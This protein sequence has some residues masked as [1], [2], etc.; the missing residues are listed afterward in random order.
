MKKPDEH[1][2]AEP[3]PL[4]AEA[5]SPSIEDRIREVGSQLRVTIGAVLAKLPG[6]PHRPNQLAKLLNCNRAVASRVLSGTSKSDPLE[7]AHIIPGPEPLRRL[8]NVAIEE[9]VALELISPA[10]L[11]VDHFD[12]LI[13][14][15]AGT[16]TALDSLISS[17]LPGA[18]ERF[19]LSNKYS[20]YKGMS[21]LKGAQAELWVGAA[22][23]APS[24]EQP[25]KHDL[26]WLNGAVAMQRL[27]RNVTIQ[28]SYRYRSDS[29]TSDPDP[30][31]LKDSSTQA[32]FGVIP[33]DQFCV[34]PPARL[35]ARSAG[36]AIHY[37][38]PDDLLGPKQAVDMFVVDHHP[39]AMNRYAKPAERH[40]N[41]LFIE[42]AMPVANL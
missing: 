6:A 18:R 8:L 39:A 19:E 7:V 17:T 16:R 5:K 41:S 22:I 12:V 15:E 26:T 3:V 14:D 31:Q 36:K 33:L 20:V 28:F 34:N 13:R 2:S 25:L 24:H 4:P 10:T 37:T 1:D 30:E 32:A 23:I 9:G 29:E 27:R 11:A 35:E 42:P 38:L 40:R 21:Q